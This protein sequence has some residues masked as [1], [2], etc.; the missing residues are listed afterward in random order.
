VGDRDVGGDSTGR[1][2]VFST[3]RRVGLATNCVSYCSCAV[4]AQGYQGG[5]DVIFRDVLSLHELLKI[6]L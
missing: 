6:V 1:G 5:V 4:R 2:G 3:A